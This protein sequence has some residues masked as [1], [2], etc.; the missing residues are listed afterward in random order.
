M[1]M[2]ISYLKIYKMPPAPG[3]TFIVYFYTKCAFGFYSHNCSWKWLSYLRSDWLTLEGLNKNFKH[4]GGS[5]LTNAKP[6]GRHHQSFQTR[7]H[8]S[9]LV[10]VMTTSRLEIVVFQI[11]PNMRLTS[12]FM[13]YFFVLSS[14]IILTV[15]TFLMPMRVVLND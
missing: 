2:L 4:N 14:V 10:L 12:C 6:S 13:H 15:W 9:L 3:V 11:T 5:W 8:S 7:F 1:P